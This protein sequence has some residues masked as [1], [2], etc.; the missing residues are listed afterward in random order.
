VLVSAIYLS[1]FLA[2]CF[3]IG[4]ELVLEILIFDF[5]DSQI[6]YPWEL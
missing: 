1:F 3:L 5:L 4:F 6:A 2:S